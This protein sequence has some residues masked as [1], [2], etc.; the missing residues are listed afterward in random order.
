[1][2]YPEPL[3]YANNKLVSY[4]SVKKLKKQDFGWRSRTPIIDVYDFGS[5]KRVQSN[6]MVA[7]T[8]NAK[9][10]TYDYVATVG[11]KIITFSTAKEPDGKYSLYAHITEQNGKITSNYISIFSNTKG[12]PSVYYHSCPDNSLL[13]I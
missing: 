13:M 6:F 11:D 7:P 12:H 2:Y 9:D 5:M 10:I 4:K 1:M 8:L 3:R